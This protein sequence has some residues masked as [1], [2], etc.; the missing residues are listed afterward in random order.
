[1]SDLTAK[2]AELKMSP[3]TK[4]SSPSKGGKLEFTGGFEQAIKALGLTRKP[5]HVYLIREEPERRAEVGHYKVGQSCD[6]ENSCNVV[7][8]ES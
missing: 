2:M 3:K 6:R 5:E 7:I 4:R 1:M 8:H